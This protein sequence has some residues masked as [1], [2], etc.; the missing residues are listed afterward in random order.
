[1]VSH[2]RVLLLRLSKLLALQIS[3][4]RHVFEGGGG[5]RVAN[6]KNEPVCS[7]YSGRNM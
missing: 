3:Q 5:G 7:L 1:M 4:N 6:L 2:K